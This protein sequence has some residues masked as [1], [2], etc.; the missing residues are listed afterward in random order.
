MIL[1]QLLRQRFFDTSGLPLAGGQLFSYIAG[2]TTPQ[3]TYSNQIGTTNTNPVVLDAYGYADVWVNPVLAYKFVLQDASNN[4]QWTVDNVTSIV[5]VPTIQKF[6]SGSGTYIL[7]AGALYLRVRMVGG[8]GGGGGSGATA[9][10]GGTGGNTTFGTALLVANGGAGATAGAA[11]GGA[12][13]TA[14]LGGLIGLA[15]SGGQGGGGCDIQ[16]NNFISG[17]NG[18]ASAFGG[19]GGG[20]VASIGMPGVTNTGGGGGGSGSSAGNTSQ[21]GAG[22]GSG[23]FVDALI[24]SPSATYA[25]AVGAA[26]TA[27]LTGGDFVGSLGGSGVIEVTE[28]YQ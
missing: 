12:G 24:T 27:G 10:A 23:G 18:G 11:S 22:G 26:G 7:P 21:S 20:T 19:A 17:G 14:S 6:T 16:I 25:Y 1:S 3:V 13:G 2:T 28:Y 5:A 4:L 15:L 8:G 9:T